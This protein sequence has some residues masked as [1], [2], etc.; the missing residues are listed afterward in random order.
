M[1]GGQ[2]SRRLLPMVQGW[3]QFSMCYQGAL[4]GNATDR[5]GMFFV[6]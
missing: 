1:K 4:K 3:S 5:F 2:P 6:D